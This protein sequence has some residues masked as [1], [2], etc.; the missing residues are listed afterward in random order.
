MYPISK[1]IM[2]R[3][4]AENSQIYSYLSAFTRAIIFRKHTKTNTHETGIDATH[5]QIQTH[6]FRSKKTH[7]LR[8]TQREPPNSPAPSNNRPSGATELNARAFISAVRTRLSEHPVEHR[9]HATDDRPTERETVEPS[10]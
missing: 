5:N 9:T 4:H 2:F 1:K 10:D 8:T 6:I 3:I 7:A